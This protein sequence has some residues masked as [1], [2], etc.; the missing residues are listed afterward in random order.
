MRRW[1]AQPDRGSGRVNA[2]A[3]RAARGQLSCSKST[4]AARGPLSCSKRGGRAGRSRRGQ[5]NTLGAGNPTRAGRK[6]SQPFGYNVPCAHPTNCT[7]GHEGGRLIACACALHMLVS[8]R[9]HE[10]Q[11]NALQEQQTRN[12]DKSNTTSNANNEPIMFCMQAIVSSAR[13]LRLIGA[14]LSEL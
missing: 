14:R 4:C 3:L 13:Y 7:R 11:R 12:D 1:P 10:I 8:T 9:M 6:R 5:L 2:H